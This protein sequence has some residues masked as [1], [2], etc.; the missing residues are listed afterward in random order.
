VELERE[1]A[2]Q[3]EKALRNPVPGISS[4]HKR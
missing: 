3:Y 1:S 2:G 4:F